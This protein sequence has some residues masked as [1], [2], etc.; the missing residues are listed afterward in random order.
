[1]IVVV[2]CYGGICAERFSFLPTST[3]ARNTNLETFHHESCL[4]SSTD[5][6]PFY[7][8]LHHPTGHV[9]AIQERALWCASLF[10][11]GGEALLRFYT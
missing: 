1:M 3:E 9:E 5:V 7:L 11:V 10:A 2:C 6:V 8:T 4:E